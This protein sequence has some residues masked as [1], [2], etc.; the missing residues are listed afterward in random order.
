MISL[1]NLIGIYKLL[2]HHCECHLV[3]G[4]CREV[5]GATVHADY[6]AGEGETDARAVGFGRKEWR[7]DVFN[8]L[9]CDRST[10]AADVDDDALA[11]IQT[12]IYS[13]PSLAS[14]RSQCLL[15]IFQ[16]I[17]QHLRHKCTIDIY[18][19]LGWYDSHATLNLVPLQ[20]RYCVLDK[21]CEQQ[22]ASLWCWDTC[23]LTKGVNK[24]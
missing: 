16:Y 12:A 14:S 15:C 9:I 19:C 4:V 11:Y 10:I 17:D 22:W 18:H 21:L 6:L 23:H 8:Y 3:G 20:D 2:Q 24:R 1:L 13:Y 5:E 7:E